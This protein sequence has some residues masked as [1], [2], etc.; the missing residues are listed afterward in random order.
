MLSDGTCIKKNDLLIKIHLHNI[1]L[2]KEMMGMDDQFLKAFYVYKKVRESMPDLSLYLSQH[3]Q[4]DHIKGIIGITMLD[5]GYKR[6]GFE[7]VPVSSKAYLLLKGISQYPIYFLFNPTSLN[8][9][10]IF[11]HYLFMSKEMIRNR[12]SVNTSE[13]TFQGSK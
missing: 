5:K 6:L 7:A 12:Y 3:P 13:P 2:L 10:Q 4:Y 9:K 1:R 8:R 11:P